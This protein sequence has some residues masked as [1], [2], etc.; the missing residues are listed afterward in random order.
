[1]VFLLRGSQAK[2]RLTEAQ[3]VAILDEADRNPVAEVAE[4]HGIRDQT[5]YVWRKDLVG[6]TLALWT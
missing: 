6:V 2:S 3:I 4:K 5:L 1:M